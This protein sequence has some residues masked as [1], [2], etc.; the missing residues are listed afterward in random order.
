MTIPFKTT[1]LILLLGGT[2]AL[3]AQQQ[4]IGDE[5]DGNR[6][7]PVHVLRLFDEDSS[8]V[9]RYDDPQLPFSTRRTCG[10]CHEYQRIAG[11]LHFNAAGSSVDPG[12]AGEP[13][14]LADP[15]T[16]TQVPLSWRNLPGT[17]DP[18]AFG[19][20]PLPFLTRFGRHFPGGGIGEEEDLQAPENFSRWLVSGALEINCLACH[21]ASPGYDPA[22]FAIQTARQNFRW[23]AAAASDFARVSGAARDMPLGFD[24]YHSVAID[25]ARKQPPKIQ[26]DWQRF[27]PEDKILLDIRREVPDEKCAFCHSTAVS[28]SERWQQDGDVHQAAGMNC[29]DCHRNGIDH[30]MVRGY[31][32]E[33]Q[34]PER[35]SLTCAGC[36]LPGEHAG[37]FGAPQPQHAG[38]PP[39]HFERLTCTACHSG[40][41]PGNKPFR[42]RTSRAHALGTRSAIRSDSLLPEIVAPVFLRQQS[43]KIAPHN[44][45]WPAF[46]AWQRGD[47]LQPLPPDHLREPAIA[48][49][50]ADSSL[51]LTGAL[52]ETA[53][54]AMLDT[55][56]VQDTTAVP[57]YLRDGVLYRSEAG[58]LV[59]ES[60]AAAAPYAWP[61][62]HDVRPAAQALGARGCGDCHSIAAPFF[63]SRVTPVHNLQNSAPMTAFMQVDHAR[64][65]LLA[66]VFAF[67][68]VLKWFIAAVSLFLIAVLLITIGRSVAGYVHMV[69]EV[70]DD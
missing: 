15:V 26:Y 66:L 2:A 63:F 5:A 7:R 70:A 40:P 20:Q 30:D 60:H 69:R 33:S 24:P 1:I 46:W 36:H 50:S 53:V 68:P 4:F 37:R 35:S 31:E 52:P 32:G 49:R 41:R 38:L 11:G 39:V 16:G 18:R 45:L 58:R 48:I 59:T 42:V 13:W 43:G 29:V 3:P 6:S 34:R 9:R 65:K 44:L 56:Q 10:G 8:A 14:L 23:A 55:L 62:A 22:E 51:S 12:R 27:T 25:D 67:R 54:L 61:I 28:S 57:V 64:N 19:L 21:D 17:H 47:T